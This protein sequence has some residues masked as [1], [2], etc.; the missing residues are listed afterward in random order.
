MREQVRTNHHIR[1]EQLRVIDEAG[2]N[3]GV[4]SLTEALKRAQD[5]GLDLIEISP[6]AKPPV[7][8]IMEFGKFLYERNKKAK[9]PKAHSTET[10][11]IQVKIGTG[12]HDLQI[13]AGR[14]SEFL[15]EGHRVRL[16][17]FLRGR[18]KYFEPKFLSERLER[19]M[20]FITVPYR[21]DGTPKPGPRGISVIIEKSK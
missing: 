19:L 11:S 2:E 17:L 18:S 15:A 1:S 8:K 16:E 21:V 10:K 4:L 7:A 12:D 6:M 13:K 9:G 14:V 3:L 5:A 20:K